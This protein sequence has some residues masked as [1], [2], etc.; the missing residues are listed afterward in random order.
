M[1]LV[2]EIYTDKHRFFVPK[3]RDWLRWLEI[4]RVFHLSNL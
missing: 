4:H 1:T 2:K 3:L